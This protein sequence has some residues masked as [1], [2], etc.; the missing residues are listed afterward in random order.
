MKKLF[1]ALILAIV[2]TTVHAQFYAGGT[3][4]LDVIHV[5]NDDASATQTTFAIAPEFGYH[6]NH[7]WSLGAMVSYGL[8]SNDGVDLNVVHFMPYVRGVFARA[9]K[10]DF[11]GELGAGYGHQS[12]GGYGVDGVVAAL[13][14]GVALNFSRKFALIAR[15]TLLQFEH[16]DGVSGVEFGLNKSFD[17]GVQFTF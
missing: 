6:F 13:R 1:L 5:S 4:G 10:V 11:F 15:S 9:G 16:W 3:I 2:G 14:P 8:Q 7:T 12:S 17:L